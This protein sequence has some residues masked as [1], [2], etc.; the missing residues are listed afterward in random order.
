[1]LRR[2]P[3]IAANVEDPDAR[4]LWD[5][6]SKLYQNDAGALTAKDLTDEYGVNTMVSDEEREEELRKVVITEGAIRCMHAGLEGAR[7]WALHNVVEVRF[8]SISRSEI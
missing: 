5:I 1:M 3:S 2:P 6:L 4:L 7:R 8:L